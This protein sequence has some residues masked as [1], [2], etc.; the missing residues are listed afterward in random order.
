MDQKRYM[1]FMVL[2]MAILLG[3]TLILPKLMPPRKPQPAAQQQDAKKGDP[4]LAE[5]KQRP[6]KDAAEND[7]EA[8]DAEKSGA[9]AA[10]ADSKQ[11][12]EQPNDKRPDQQ[13]QVE[14]PQELPKFLEQT[15]QLGSAEFSSGYRE[16]VKLTSHGAAVQEVQLNDARY[17]TLEK[18]HEPLKVI[19]ESTFGTATLELSVLPLPADISHLNWELVEVLPAEGPHSSAVFR[20]R[21]DDLEIVKRYELAKADPGDVRRGEA[22]A[23]ALKVDLTFKNL[24]KKQRTTHYVLQGPTGLPLENVENAQKYQDVVA[25]FQKESGSID[26]QLMAAKTI[27]EGKGEEWKNTA[28]KYIGV[29]VQFFAALLVPEE[30]QLLSPYTRSLK[31]E[32]V[33]PNLK[34][35]SDVSVQLTSV[36]LTLEKAGAANNAD[37]ITHSYTLFAGPK[38]DDVLP[39]GTEK[40]IDFGSIFGVFPGALAWISRQL[41]AVLMFF[42]H[43]TGSWGLA[44][45]CLTICVRGAMFPISIKQAR[46]AAKMQ[47]IQPEIAALKQ[48]YGN[49]KEKFARAQMELFRKHNHNPFA[50]CLPVFLQLPIFMGLYQALNHAVDLR[51]AKFLWIDNLAAPDMLFPMPFNLPFLGHDFNLLPIITVALFVAQQKMFMPPPANE[52]QAMQQKVMNFMM[53]FMGVMFYKVPA[54]LCVY[55]IASSLWGMA[56]RKLLPKAKPGTPPEP[57][58]S[59]PGAGGAPGGGGRPPRKPESDDDGFWARLLKAAEKET[60]ARRAVDKR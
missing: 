6:E 59:G 21:V 20:I 37:Q 26:N 23:Y 17:L 32:L 51:L 12:D 48:K 3:W 11:A 55:F 46:S 60:A 43:L 57:S 18:P 9:E 38:R 50:G 47:A 30:D 22:Q 8:G 16:L 15:V 7:A 5:D 28:I 25:G 52:E 19:K 58:P 24:G 10:I 56:E 36:D 40:V 14:R 27:A 44:V 13:P 42:H 1:A 41:L 31:Q 45:I 33:G 35:K 49:D 53:I 29:D 34:E 54:G 2:S 4:L 39:V